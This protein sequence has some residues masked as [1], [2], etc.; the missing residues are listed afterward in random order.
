MGDYSTFER[1]SIVG[2]NEGSSRSCLLEEFG[3]RYGRGTPLLLAIT[4]SIKDVKVAKSML[5]L[6][7]GQ[8]PSAPALQHFTVLVHRPCGI[9]S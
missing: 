2:E 1:A 4:A 9:R 3:S 5:L 6:Y 7:G 8:A